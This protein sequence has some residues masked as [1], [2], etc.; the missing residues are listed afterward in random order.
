MPRLLIAT[1]IARTIDA[2]LV[3]YA[4]HF[5]ALGWE[6]DALA[7][8][9]FGPS[10]ARHFTQ[11]HAAPWSRNPFSP[12]NL[13]APRVLRRLQQQRGY[14]IVHVHTPVAAL[15]TR[16]ALRSM[17]QVGAPRVV[18]TAH[19][20]HF[21]SRGRHPTNAAFRVLERIGGRWTD[22]LIVINEEDERAA[23][24]HSIVAPDA[25]VRMPG[26]GV[27]IEGCRARRADP[28]VIQKVR[29]ELAIE[30]GAPYFLV[31]AE[32]TRNKRHAN[33]VRALAGLRAS[34]R[35]AHLVFAGFGAEESRVRQLAGSLSLS[36]RVHFLG[37]RRDVP[38]LMTGASALVLASVREGLPRCVLEA[39]AIGTPVI[40][41][42]ARGTTELLG[43]DC[44][45][46]V[47]IDDVGSLAS[48]M[49]GVVDDPERALARARRAADRVREYG[50][51]EVLRLHEELYGRLLGN[52]AIAAE[53]RTGRRASA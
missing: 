16:F 1:T 44:G 36:N 45:F 51:G 52:T 25:L 12:V 29:D 38:A 49:A 15:V 26:I 31:V 34:G 18:Y 14:D 10:L 5:R 47:A 27:D 9:E 21:H 20:F 46:L 48:A 3:P 42:R 28:E 22:A 37:Y 2:F 53:A 24:N 33:V 50:L 30:R 43:D 32:F 19:G 35:E 8:D 39:M 13:S 6:V 23:I 41:T 7:G 40:G 11:V 17:R 4:E